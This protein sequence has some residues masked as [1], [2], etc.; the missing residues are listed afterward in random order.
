MNYYNFGL[1]IHLCSLLQQG[2]DAE[3]TVSGLSIV[4]APQASLFTTDS[5]SKKQI[6]RSYK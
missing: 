6:K 1:N 5:I 4:V 3:F 2:I